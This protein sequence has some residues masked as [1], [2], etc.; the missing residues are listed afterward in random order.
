MKNIM[1]KIGIVGIIH[2]ASLAHAGAYQQ[3]LDMTGG[4]GYIPPVSGPECVSG[5]GNSD[6]GYDD[7]G[8]RTSWIEAIREQREEA[9]R[10]AEQERIA[11]E[12]KRKQEAFNL[13]ESGN[14]AYEKQQWTTAIDFY[15][16]ALEKSPY[17]TVIKSNLDGAKRELQWEKERQIQRTEYRNTMG[18]LSA[19]MPKSKPKSIENDKKK[20][21]VPMPGFSMEQWK[22]YLEAKELVNILYAK[23]NR[24]GKLSDEDAQKFYEALNRRNTLWTQA[25]E[26]PMEDVQREKLKL[27]LPTVVHKS[28]LNIDSLLNKPD[29][30]GTSDQN[31]DRHPDPRK[32]HGPTYPDPIM[33]V[34]ESNFFA[35]KGAEY[36][37]YEVG[38]TIES[39]HGDAMKSRYENLL[40]IGHIA[41]EAKENG[42]AGALAETTDFII[43]KIPE[44]LSLHAGF[45]VEGGRMYSNVT[46]HAMNRFMKDAMKAT[47]REFDPEAFWKEFDEELTTSQKGVK[48]WIGFGE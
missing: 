19:L 34:F 6:S 25:T 24:D 32:E 17:D 37:E 48:Q 41:I 28:L 10:Q 22:E 47:G 1:M 44:P 7:G 29:S 5:C 33:T 27:Y 45:A 2:Y 42:T 4:S 12:K 23:L 30:A 40:G 31:G 21:I 13:N 8:D 35:D 39:V 43:S 20:N 11:N 36:I 16:K 15:E 38:E 46:Y 14:R 9:E 26:Q 3:L 18:K